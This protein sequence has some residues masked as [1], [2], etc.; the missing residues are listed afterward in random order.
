MC[1]A[2]LKPL[3][4]VGQHDL[5]DQGAPKLQQV[6]GTGTSFHVRNSCAPRG[7]HARNSL[8]V[9]PSTPVLESRACPGVESTG[10][11]DGGSRPPSFR[12]ATCWLLS[13]LV[14]DT[15]PDARLRLAP[16]TGLCRQAVRTPPF[17]KWA[18]AVKARVEVV[19]VGADVDGPRSAG[20]GAA[21]RDGGDRAA[22]APRRV[23][24]EDEVDRWHG[25]VHGQAHQGWNAGWSAPCLQPMLP[26][27]YP[28]CA[29][30]LTMRFDKS[31]PLSGRL[32]ANIHSLSGEWCRKL[33]TH[34][35][36]R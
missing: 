15:S 28:P 17:S 16:V 18:P 14:S 4:L 11:R 19:K 21:R 36:A 6:A 31:A 23:A 20:R 27:P 10:V 13:L 29:T 12:I 26:D 30:P 32:N 7:R 22:A 2:G 1:A 5:P 33:Q 9:H 8:S 25:H 3:P 35:S 34:R 24:E